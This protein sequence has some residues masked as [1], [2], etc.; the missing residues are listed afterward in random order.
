MT[1]RVA[2]F[3][4]SLLVLPCGSAVAACGQPDGAA[5]RAVS[6]SDGRTLQLADG[7]TI[8]LAGLEP[9][10]AYA[11]A[12]DGL[13]RRVADADLRLKILDSP[14]RYG[15]LPAL[16][17]VNGSE[18]PLQYDL[19]RAGLVRFAGPAAA[20]CRA[21]LLAQER[22][23]RAAKVGL[24]GNPVYD[25]RQAENPAA[26]GAERGRFVLVQGKVLSVRDSG[27]TIYVNFGRRWSEDFTATI[28]R[29]LAPLF[30]QAGLPP[31]G[32]S[33]RTVRLRGV[34]EERGGPWIELARPDQ[35][36][37]AEATTP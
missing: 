17:F 10:P 35:I 12:R 7:R 37:L 20:T 25:I 22:T 27:G 36:E 29:R 13:A 23:A 6:V 1:V 32:L 33:G 8:V 14:D 11:G 26:M 9:A 21:A 4:V 19:L 16:V 31:Q 3:A 28:P 5:V 15:R 2:V 34:L 24:W 30:A 18:T